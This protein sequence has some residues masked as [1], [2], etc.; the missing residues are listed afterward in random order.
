MAASNAPDHLLLAQVVA[1][2]TGWESR[3]PDKLR[4]LGFLMAASHTRRGSFR[5]RNSEPPDPSPDSAEEASLFLWRAVLSLHLYRFHAVG[6]SGASDGSATPF[7][8]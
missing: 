8:F 3:M 1:G 7:G 2:K 4:A 6:S 5:V